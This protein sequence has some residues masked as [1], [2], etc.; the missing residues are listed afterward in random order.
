MSQIEGKDKH[1]SP[2]GEIISLTN[3]VVT[4]EI[5]IFAPKNPKDYITMTNENQV[6]H[7][8]RLVHLIADDNELLSRASTFMQNLVNSKFDYRGREDISAELAA[9]EKKKGERP[10]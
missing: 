10:Q 9:K 5:S 8:E 3:L 1:F 4:T 6:D 2:N 7:L